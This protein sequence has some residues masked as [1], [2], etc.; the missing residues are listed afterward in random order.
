MIAEEILLDMLTWTF[1][2]L[3]WFIV[4]LLLLKAVLYLK[5]ALLLLDYLAM[6]GT[7]I[8][9]LGHFLACKIHG[10]RVSEVKWF[11]WGYML[12]YERAYHRT[13]GVVGYVRRA[14][15]PNS[16][17]VQFQISVAPLISGGLFWVLSL[18]GVHLL[19]S[20]SSS[21]T[22]SLPPIYEAAT[23]GILLWVGLAASAR[24][25][26]SD[27]DMDNVLKW[28]ARNP[29]HIFI[30][31]IAWLVFLANKVFRGHVEGVRSWGLLTT[32]LTLWVLLRFSIPGGESYIEPFSDLSYIIQGIAQDTVETLSEAATD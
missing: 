14:E 30:H 26:P 21:L 8:H 16:L 31:L 10:I 18:F 11:H 27:T 22:D 7:I 19:I 15:S 25:L 12:N 5:P 2:G 24:M 13:G 28:S 17:F 9:E 23:V 1:I 32:L 4:A 20:E 3:L 6:P 29:L